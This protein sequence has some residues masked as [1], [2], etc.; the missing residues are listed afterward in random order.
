LKANIINKKGIIKLAQQ[1][2]IVKRQGCTEHKIIINYGKQVTQSQFEIFDLFDDVHCVIGMNLLSKIG[3]TIGNIVTDWSDQIGYEIPEVDPSPYKPNETPF[4]TPEQRSAMLKQLESSIEANKNISPKAYCTIPDSEIRLPI[5]TDTQ[6]NTH[7]RQFPIAEAL[8]PIVQAQVDKWRDNGIIKPAKPGTPH[9]SPIFLVRKKNPQGEYAGDYRVVIDCRLINAALDPARIE[10]FPLPLISELHKKMSKHSL[11]TV[12]DLS[13]CFH[14]FK[15]KRESRPYLTFTDM[16]GFTWSF[17]HCPFGIT[18]ISSVCQRILSILFEDLK[19]MVT[20]FIDDVTIHTE[21]DLQKH[22]EVVKMVLDRLTKVNLRVNTEKMHFAQKSIFILG[23]C[24]SE[25]GLALDPRKVSNILDWTPTVANTRELS[26]RLG[27]INFFRSHLPNLSTL[28]AP[29]DKLRNSKNLKADW[30]QEHSNIMIKL[31]QLL[32]SAPILSTPNLKYDMCLVTDSSAFGIGAA[33]YQVINNRV[34]YLG[35]IARRLAP[36]ETRWGSSKR[37]LAAVAYAFQRFHQWLY[38][39]RFHLFVDNTG[40]LYLHSKEKINRM[41]ENFYDTIFRMDFDIT[42]CMG[43]KNILADQLSRIFWPDSLVEGGNKQPLLIHAKQ[44]LENKNNEEAERNEK[45]KRKAKKISNPSSKK[46][47]HTIESMESHIHAQGQLNNEHKQQQKDTQNNYLQKGKEKTIK[48]MTKKK[49]KEHKYIFSACGKVTLKEWT[50][51]DIV[52][53][54]ETT[55]TEETL[56]LNNTNGTLRNE[57][58]KESSTTAIKKLPEMDRLINGIT[59]KEFR[60]LIDKLGHHNHLEEINYTE[61]S[62]KTD[63][64]TNPTQVVNMHEVNKNNETNAPHKIDGKHDTGLTENSIHNIPHKKPSYA[65]NLYNPDLDNY[66]DLELDDHQLN[67]NTQNILDINEAISSS[68]S[69]NYSST[70]TSNHNMYI[71]ASRLD[72]YQ[73]P[74]NEEEKQDILEKSHLLGHFGIHAMESVI[75][76]DLNYH[77]K[78]MREDITNYIRKCHKCQ[79][80]NLAKHV[81]HPPKQETPEG[82]FDH[83]VFDLGTFDCTTPRGNNFMLVVMDLFSRFIILRA[84]PDKTAV[85]IAKELVSIFSLFGYPRIVGHDNGR[86]FTSILLENI[87]KHAGVENRASLPFSPQGNGCCEA[88]VKTSKTII[89]K[90]LEGR[91]EDWDLYIDGTALCLNIHRTRLH[92][93]RPFTVMFHREPNEFKDYTHL[94]PVLPEQDIDVEAFKQKLDMIDRIIV[95]AIRDQIMKTQKKDST[96]FRKRHRILEN[97]YPIGATVMIK[98]IENKNN[99]T[100][101]NYEGPF[102]IHGHTRNGSYILVDK[103]NTFLARDVPTQQLKLVSTDKI[104][105]TDDKNVYEVEAILKHKGSAPNYQ[106]LTRWKSYDADHDTWEPSNSFDSIEPIKA[107]WNRFNAANPNAK[108]TVAPRALRTR[109]I[110]T[111]EDRSR[112]RR[113]RFEAP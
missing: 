73:T 60:E 24:M 64:Q 41:V 51:K 20:H 87:L 80:F 32:V 101:P 12:V 68:S 58:N 44:N 3:I 99:K 49:P 2:N 90:M 8:R 29:L 57:L 103:T 65:E 76:Q 34:Y 5:R 21:N 22:T 75:H 77:W 42:Y 91:R 33:L 86:E 81:Y 111:R 36:S 46:Q 55:N 83:I 9:N 84:I 105:Q 10:R 79:K 16:N 4:G 102:Y 100:D 108:H 92:G 37:E 98:N 104:N 45:Q 30:T 38:G 18:M 27:L 15:I 23:F 35:F 59:R 25:K 61:G 109:R 72:T 11:F 94:T 74:K 31:Q 71:C 40:L 14:S 53:D 19:D 43:M 62:T 88:A 89:M 56:N 26:S 63:T 106:Y 48:Q 110:P 95:P 67:I 97:P 69:S 70:T 13:Q 85:T 113:A 93:M 6:V 112:N 50:V 96:Y 39:R 7:R 107:Y 54:K 28:T 78:G 52:K 47:K 1:N 66:P 17:A 82:I